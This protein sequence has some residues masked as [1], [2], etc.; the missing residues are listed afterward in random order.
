MRNALI[1]AL[2]LSSL[3][4]F[5]WGESAGS[6]ENLPPPDADKFWAYITQNNPYQRWTLW[7]GYPGISPGKSPHGA[8]LKLYANPAALKAA[9]EGS[10]MPYGGLIIKENYAEDQKT[11]MAVTPMYKVRDYYPEGGDWFWGKYG[12]DGQVLVAGK[13][14][15]CISC[16]EA[17]KDKDWLFTAP[18]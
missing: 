10:P 18:R 17:V 4:M 13:P 12:P 5:R 7:P 9:R 8:Y 15:G 2:V 16:H 1:M 6:G 3:V 11:L 14:Q